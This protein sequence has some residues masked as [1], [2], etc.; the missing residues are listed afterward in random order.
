MDYLIAVD[1][2]G[3]NIRS[4]LFHA[5]RDSYIKINKIKTRPSTEKTV[6]PLDQILL[7]IKNI[8]PKEGKVLGICA[9]APGSIL[10]DEGVVLL[11]P[12]IPGWKN[13]SLAKELEKIFST[14][15][16][17]NNDARMAAYGEWKKGAGIGHNNL[18]YITISTG[19]GGGIIV[20][21]KLLQGEKGLATEV[22]HI[23]IVEGGDL[24]GC[25]KSGH[26]EA[27]SSGTAI[28][29]F[30]RSQIKKSPESGNFFRS[31]S[32]KASEIATAAREGSPLAKEAFYRAGYYLGV[33]IANY[34]HIFNP[35]CV[36][37]GG[38]V[39]RSESLYFESFRKSL[40]AHVLNREYLKN[41]TISRAKLGDNSGLIGCVEYLRDSLH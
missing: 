20:N 3:T 41:L 4:A 10:V 34:L 2:G 9:A 36:I 22:G 21:G 24:C 29:N 25:G 5:N 33:G 30:V 39:S 14:R 18:L 28:E 37:I 17:V 38:G 15:V 32:P 11:A 16:L 35:S 7:S 6:T 19:L 12:N 13:I 26:L 31:P 8:W 1:I 23:T 27:Y 40:E